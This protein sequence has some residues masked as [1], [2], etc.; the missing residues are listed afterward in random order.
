M[1]PLSRMLLGA[2]GGGFISDVDYVANTTAVATETNSN[3]SITLTGIESGDIVF[4][5]WSADNNIWPDIEDSWATT[6]GSTWSVMPGGILS[7]DSPSLK[8]YWKEATGTSITVDTGFTPGAT[9]EEY[10]MSLTAFRGADTTNPVYYIGTVNQ[11]SYSLSLADYTDSLANFNSYLFAVVGLDD[12]INVTLT[13]PGTYTKI[14]QVA[15]NTTNGRNATQSSAYSEYTANTS[16]SVESY[17]SSNIDTG[18]THLWLLIPSGEDYIPVITGSTTVQAATGGTAVATYTADNTVTWSLGGTDASLFSISSGGVV[19]YNSAS[20]LGRYSI[21]VIATNTNGLKGT[22]AV[23]VDAY[24][25]SGS[26]GGGITYVNAVSGRVAANGSGTLTLTGLQSGD[27]IHWMSAS[28]SNIGSQLSEANSW[29]GWSARELISS[30]ASPAVLLRTKIASS[31]S[32]TV[33]VDVTSTS[34]PQAIAHALFAFRGVD[35]TDPILVNGLIRSY[36]SATASVY[37]DF[38]LTDTVRIIWG[39]L[40]DDQG[41]SS[42]PP[43]GYTE[44]VDQNSYPSGTSSLNGATLTVAYKAVT[45]GT[46]ESSVDFTFTTS[47]SSYTGSWQYMPD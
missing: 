34:S 32:E 43:S 35:N 12:D 26:P 20:T 11:T 28:D 25:T 37:S 18:K 24:E 16:R 45:G 1:D 41:E 31:T 36:F 6:E 7:G 17:T 15:S 14:N 13:P 27:V 44:I 2:S 33:D 4:F 30:S 21:N 23:T 46:T 5:S 42:T 10:S 19:T 47:D 29:S 39:G 3:T 8:V 9:E 40:D 22:L 38:M